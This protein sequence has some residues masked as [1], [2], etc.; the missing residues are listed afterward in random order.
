MFEILNK[1]KKLYCCFTVDPMIEQ[2][3]ANKYQL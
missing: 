2:F 1:A 3:G